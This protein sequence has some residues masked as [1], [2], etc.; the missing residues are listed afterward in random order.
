MR[1]SDKDKRLDEIR[2][3]LVTT[4][5]QLSIDP[6][7][8]AYAI[9]ITA[10]TLR[11]REKAYDE[12]MESGGKNVTEKGRSNAAAVRLATWNAQSRACL[13]MLK[14]TPWRVLAEHTEECDE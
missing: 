10:E 13:A 14:L 9:K 4:M 6:T 7:P 1:K 8:Y 2:D 3:E 11:E 12:Y 5:R